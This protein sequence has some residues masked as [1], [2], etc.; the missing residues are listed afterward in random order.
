MY[1]YVYMLCEFVSLSLSLYLSLLLTAPPQHIAVQRAV[2]AG[3]KEP[4]VMFT[5]HLAGTYMH[6]HMYTVCAFVLSLTHTDLL[7]YTYTYTHIHTHIYIYTDRTQWRL[8]Q[9]EVQVPAVFKS[10]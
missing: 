7:P 1:L 10:F 6:M 9:E 2:D 4:S 5:S 8:R 3:K